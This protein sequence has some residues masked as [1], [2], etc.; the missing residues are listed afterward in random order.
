MAKADQTEEFD[1]GDLEE[2][3]W[4]AEQNCEWKYNGQGSD[5]QF[6]VGPAFIYT[7]STSALIMGFALD[8]FNRPIIM[9]VGIMVFSVSCILMGIANSFWQLIV[10][11]MGIALGEAVCRPAASSL[12]AEFF[13]PDN[14]GV[15]N[16]IF[17]WGVYFGY[18]MAYI[19]GVYLTKAD[20]FGFGWRASY[21]IGGLPGI[22][23]SVAILFTVRDPRAKSDTS[24]SDDKTPAKVNYL[25]D[26]KMAYSQPTMI[27]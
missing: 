3:E 11:R 5:F 7:F 4:V 21:V 25:R 22:L 8:K 6:L 27:L 24:K 14:R 18:G 12:I 26:L 13:S 23:I 2:G 19:F 15:A 16:G 20:I 10:L 17:S 1:C 9:S